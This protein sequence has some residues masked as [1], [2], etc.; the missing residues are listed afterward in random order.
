MSSASINGIFAASGENP[1][2]GIMSGDPDRTWQRN[3][4]SADMARL[5]LTKRRLYDK[6]DPRY[7]AQYMRLK[8]HSR[9]A[10]SSRSVESAQSSLYDLDASDTEWSKNPMHRWSRKRY[11]SFWPHEH[12][13]RLEHHANSLRFPEANKPS[14]VQNNANHNAPEMIPEDWSPRDSTFSGTGWHRK[15]ITRGGEYSPNSKTGKLEAFKVSPRSPHH[16]NLHQEIHGDAYASDMSG[17]INVNESDDLRNDFSQDFSQFSSMYDPGEMQNMAFSVGVGTTGRGS[18]GYLV[19]RTADRRPQTT[20][21]LA[22][23][24]GR[25]VRV[26]R[27]VQFQGSYVNNRTRPTASRFNAP[28]FDFGTAYDKAGFSGYRAGN[29]PSTSDIDGNDAHGHIYDRKEMLKLDNAVRN[30]NVSGHEWGRKRGNWFERRVNVVDHAYNGMWP[31]DWSPVGKLSAMQKQHREVEMNNE[32]R[33]R[34]ND[35]LWEK[36]MRRLRETR[37]Y[38]DF[39]SSKFYKRSNKAMQRSL[40]IDI[41]TAGDKYAGTLLRPM[42]SGNPVL[43]SSSSPVV[44]KAG[45]GGGPPLTKDSDYTNGP[46]MPS[47]THAG[48]KTTDCE[49]VFSMNP[50]HNRSQQLSDTSKQLSNVDGGENLNSPNR[51]PNTRQREAQQQMTAIMQSQ[52]SGNFPNLSETSRDSSAL[53]RA[54]NSPARLSKEPL[55]VARSQTIVM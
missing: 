51:S 49:S 34:A 17:L 21:I 12:T 11:S 8:L 39:H 54:V 48:G 50:Q 40:T 2:T 1:Y 26:S 18:R 13:L 44:N 43:A 36:T 24:N 30:K 31:E 32:R 6:S 15:S 22:S 37:M 10:R 23:N 28:G 35:A 16:K 9:Q 53:F 45:G 14:M 20:P 55:N 25:S 27:N 7:A 29:Y 19:S 5:S 47:S 4:K 38:D 3:L 52:G 41:P 42:E 33:K 46:L